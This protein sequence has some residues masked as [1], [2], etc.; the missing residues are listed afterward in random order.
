MGSK[1]FLPY[2]RI[3]SHCY[4]WDLR[5]SPKAATAP[6]HTAVAG[7]FDRGGYGDDTD[8]DTVSLRKSY[9]GFTVSFIFFWCMWI[10]PST[11]D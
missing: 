11:T 2:R 1:M 3:F 9:D 8:C 5:P 10:V 7:N 6:I 4:D